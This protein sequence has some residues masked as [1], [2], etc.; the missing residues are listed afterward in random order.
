MSSAARERPNTMSARETTAHESEKIAVRR[1]PK[2]SITTEPRM[3]KAI[4][5]LPATPSSAPASRS[6]RP[7]SLVM[8]EY[9][10]KRSPKLRYELSSSSR[11]TTKT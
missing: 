8:N 2:R 5:T 9:L 3:R 6:E 11:S 10:T 4:D 7:Y 1:T